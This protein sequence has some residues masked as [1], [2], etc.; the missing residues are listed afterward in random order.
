MGFADVDCFAAQAVDDLEVLLEHI[1][2]LVIFAGDIL[3]DGVG[4]D[5]AVGFAE[6]EEEDVAWGL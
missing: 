5:E 6:G 2:V 4:E 3:P 1:G